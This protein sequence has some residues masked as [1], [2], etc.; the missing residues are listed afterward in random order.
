MSWEKKNRLMR[1]ILQ[2]SRKRRRFGQIFGSPI[3]SITRKHHQVKKIADDEAIVVKTHFSST[4]M[5]FEEAKSRIKKN[6]S[7]AWIDYRK[8]FDSVPYSG[9]KE[10]LEMYEVCPVITRF[11]VENTKPWKTA[12][13][14]NHSRESFPSGQ[15]EIKWG[16][17]MEILYHHCFSVLP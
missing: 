15:R 5:V 3:K 4:K 2:P 16:I 10:T 1:T 17:F 7:M 14:L 11:I 8:A 9:I 6:L 12:L 13:Q